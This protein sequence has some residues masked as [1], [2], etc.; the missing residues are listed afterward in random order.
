[1]A[2]EKE[3]KGVQKLEKKS[4]VPKNAALI[5]FG[6]HPTKDQSIDI[7]AKKTFKIYIKSYFLRY[8]L[9]SDLVKTGVSLEYIRDNWQLIIFPCKNSTLIEI[10][11][12]LH[13]SN[14]D[15]YPFDTKNCLK[16]HFAKSNFQ[17]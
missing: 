1:M 11:I 12:N 9:M 16:N 5:N 13:I 3:Q 10:G 7:K 14:R 15:K 17:S 4:H 8:I 2:E 6:V